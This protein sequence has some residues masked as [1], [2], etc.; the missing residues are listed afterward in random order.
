MVE[1]ESNTK[2]ANKQ[3]YY[4]DIDEW[5]YTKGQ[6]KE[7]KDQTEIHSKCINAHT[8]RSDISLPKCPIHSR[9]MSDKFESTPSNSKYLVGHRG[10]TPSIWLDVKVD[11]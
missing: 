1:K 11:I 6:G 9:E 2:W 7:R 4:Y 3:F 5:S 10:C 8:L